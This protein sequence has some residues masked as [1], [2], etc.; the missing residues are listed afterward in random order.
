VSWTNSLTTPLTDNVITVKL[1]GAA[2]DPT[3][4]TTSG[5]YRSSDTSIVFSRDTVP[6]LARL[7]PGDKGT[8][9]FTFKTKSAAALGNQRNPVVTATISVAARRA[10]ESGVPENLSATATR[11]IQVGTDFV[12]GAVATHASGAFKNSG[13]LPPVPDRETTYTIA[14][15]L[16]SSVNSVGGASVS[17]LLPSYVRF[18]GAT[19]PSDGSITYNAASRTVTWNAGDVAAGT[20]GSPKTASFQVAFLPSIGQQGTSPVLMSQ[21]TYVGVDRFTRRQLTGKSPER[22]IQITSDSGYQPAFGTVAK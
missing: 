3:S 18:T 8:G 14:W 1:D 15:S 21:A 22:T 13:P 20:L 19:S 2:L 17:A 5:F 10:G 9:F 16:G 11:T 12:F 7:A 4:I 6:S